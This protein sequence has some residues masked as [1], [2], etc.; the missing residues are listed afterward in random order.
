M[1]RNEAMRRVLRTAAVLAL[2][3]STLSLA[4]CSGNV[5]VGVSV[6]VP[7]GNHGYMSVG[8]SRWY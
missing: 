3:I 1:N 5:G 2:V 8:T 6:G 4:G 7:I